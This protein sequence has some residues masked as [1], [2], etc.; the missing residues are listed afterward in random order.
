MLAQA[1]D[2]IFERPFV[3]AMTMIAGQNDLVLALPAPRMGKTP[4]RKICG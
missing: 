2:V 1:K 4:V 3:L